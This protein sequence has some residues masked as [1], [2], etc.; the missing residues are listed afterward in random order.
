[1]RAAAVTLLLAGCGPAVLGIQVDLLTRACPDATADRNPIAGVTKLR[2]GLSGDGLQTQT[3]TAD[4]SSGRA[5][6]PNIPIGANRRLTVEALDG[7][8]VRA[9]ADSGRFDALG[10]DDVH[11]RLFLRNVDAF[12]LTSDG[13]ASCTHMSAPRAGHAMALLPDGRVLISG[14]YSFDGSPQP[15]L[16]YHDD[17]EV[18]D[19]ATGSFSPLVPGPAV[20]RA[21]HAALSVSGESGDGIL[22]AGGEGPT[23][24]AGSVGAIKPFE[25]FAKGIWTELTPTGTTPSRA[26]A[27]SA[28]DLKTG[29]A[30]V[31]GGQAGPDKPGVSVFNT[32]TYFDPATN[33]LKDAAMPLRAGLLT[34]A[35]AVARANLS[36]KTPLGGVV[37]VGGRDS[38]GNVLAQVSGLIWGPSPAGSL[39]FVDDATFK[40]APFKLPT[41]RAHHVAV[42]T[43]DDMVLTGGG[44]TALT[45][46][47]FDYSNA[48]A[49]ITLIDPTGARVYDLPDPLSQARGDSCAALLDEGSV[50]IAG[51]AWKDGSGIHSAR[52]VD[53]VAP[54]HSVRLA[55]GPPDGS[56][57][58]LLQAGRHKAACLK[59]RDGSVLVSGGLQYS[60]GGVAVL[61]TAE[62]YMPSAA[63]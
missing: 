50:L 8:R 22:L 62:I 28:V 61:D 3:I 58:G 40:A 17:A 45:V 4:L 30:L 33:S 39:D 44:V 59:L 2:I 54:D 24:S 49:A 29:A 9:R 10:P 15:K 7:T 41:P 38:N 34:D 18:F 16:V 52:S 25:L 63:Q 42:R 11:L 14:G 57:D 37:L 47:A 12:T 48:T 5:Q 56:G 46:G 51:G 1:M 32:V 55:R 27:A 6:I 26:H 19:P 21:G 36:G 35:V 31:I 43:I 53:L 60:S 13:N 20:R 23:D